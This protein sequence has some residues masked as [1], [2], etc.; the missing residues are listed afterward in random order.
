MDH[1]M[2]QL[3]KSNANVLLGHKCP[4]DAVLRCGRFATKE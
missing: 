3:T 4:C 2:W 1:M